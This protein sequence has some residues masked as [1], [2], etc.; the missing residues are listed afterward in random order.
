MGDAKSDQ[1]DNSMTNP[2][3]GLPARMK[4]FGNTAQFC[5]YH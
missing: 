2:G 1:R 5:F 4:F 3:R